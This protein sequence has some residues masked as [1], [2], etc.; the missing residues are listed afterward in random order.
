LALLLLGTVALVLWRRRGSTGNMAGHFFT[1]GGEIMEVTPFNPTAPVTT[2]AALSTLNL[3][4]QVEQQQQLSVDES[5]FTGDSLFSTPFVAP[6]TVPVNLTDKEL[7][8]LRSLTQPSSS[9]SSTEPQPAASSSE[10]PPIITT[11]PAPTVTVPVGLSD[12]ELAD[13]R[14]RSLA[15]P[16]L[17]CQPTNELSAQ[18]PAS[19]SEVSPS[20]TTVAT[21]ATRT[22]ASLVTFPS[23]EEAERHPSWQSEVE[24]LRREVRQLRAE[25]F[26]PPPS[27]ASDVGV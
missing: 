4:S 17:L 5:S 2:L 21:V 1:P 12:K 7:A 25:R 11:L 10:V 18:P 8:H 19:P 23:R 3:E 26:E 15:R 6:V 16:Q 20:V 14:S 24:S 22:N 13:L 27:Y 9:A